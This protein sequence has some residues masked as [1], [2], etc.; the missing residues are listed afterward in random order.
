MYLNL[1]Y[2]D[3]VKRSK[4]K[5]TAGGRHHISQTMKPISPNLV[6]YVFGFVDLLI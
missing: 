6:I 2:T 5:V 3:Y 1:G 4:F